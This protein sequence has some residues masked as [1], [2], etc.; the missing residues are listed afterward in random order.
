MNTKSK[1]LWLGPVI[2]A[3]LLVVFIA[4]CKKDDFK[5][6]P[7]VCPLVLSTNPT[8]GATSVPLNQIITATFNVKMNPLTINQASFTLQGG[9][10]TSVSGTISYDEA[11]A[12]LSFAPTTALTASTT[13]TGTIKSTV[14]DLSGSSLQTNYI[15]TFSTGNQITPSVIATDPAS[16]ATSVFLNKIVYATFSMEM[17]PLTIT[18]STFTLKQGT[19]NVAGTVAYLGTTASFN[20]SAA[21]ASNVLYTATITTAAK[22]LAGVPMV[23]NY[24]WTFTTGS[25]LAPIVI[26]TVPANNEA[27]VLLS[28][29]VTATFSVPMD[30]LTITSATFLLKN[31]TASVAGTVTFSGSTATFNPANDLLQNTVYTGTITVGAKNP[32]GT[33]LANNYQWTFT[34]ISTTPPLVISTDPIN[35]ATDV[36]LD[37]VVTATF[38]MPMDPLS[39]T[40]SSFTLKTGL[41]SVT[42]IVTYSG[43]T[44]YFDP[45]T[46]LLPNTLYT[47]IIT[48]GAKN[49]AG[50]SLA[51]NYSW[52][53]TTLS[54]T[55]PTI[56]LTD[57][58]NLATNVVLNKIV[59]AN[60]SMPMDPLSIN[61]LTFSLK[62]GSTAVTGLVSYLGTTASF[63]STTILLPGTVYTATITTGAKSIA[64]IAMASNYVWTFTTGS[65]VAP[66]VIST[67]PANN[68]SA[69]SL[70]KTIAASFSVAMNPL[71]INTTTFLLYNG[72]T[73]VTGVVSYSG[74]TASFN[75]AIDLLP[76][77]MY[78]ATIT[79][80]VENVAGIPLANNYVWTF[81]TLE[82]L[83][84]TV[85][86]T[87]P[88][89]N[90]TNV[91][92]NQTLE[93]IFSVPMDPLTINALTF[94]LFNGTTAVTG[95]VSYSGTT[96][97]FNPA[98]DLLPGTMYTATITNAAENVAGTPLANNYVWTF[99]TLTNPAPT[100]I[101]TVPANNAVN[102]ALDQSLEAT[103]SEAM[104]ATTLNAST[105]IM[106][107]G[108]NPVAGTISYS[109]TTASF[110]PS[111]DLLAGTEYTATI[112]TGA[113]NPDGTALE[114]DYVWTFTTLSLVAP[115][116]IS[117]IPANNESNVAINQI[118]S[119]TFS[120]PMDPMTITNLTFT[121]FEGA[122]PVI[123][124]ISYSGS[125]A[126]FTPSAALLSETVYTASITTGAMNVDGIPMENDYDWTFTTLAVVVPPAVDLLTV[127][128][129]G[130]IAGAGVSN[131]AGFSVINNLDVGISPGLRSS[132][133]GFPPAVIVNGEIYAADDAAPTPAML[134]QAKL[135]LTAAYL[136]AEGATEPAPATVSGDQGGLSLAPGIYKTTSTLLIQ[137]GDLT[138]DAG[139]DEN[140]FW[141]FQ[142][143]TGFTSIGG[144]GGSVILSG[145]AQAKNVFWQ[146]GSSATIGDYTTFQG[147]VLALT[148]ITMNSHATIS[149][150]VLCINGA[151]VMTDT[152]IITRP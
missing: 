120:E 88:A 44:V 136:Y 77:T 71:T 19:S 103:F 30:P 7:G 105:F 46:A 50:I 143:A 151:V 74:T 1:R 61:A 116:V 56:T 144:A 132:V 129:F 138:L 52:S 110:N 76:G 15:W 13:Y 79:N 70:D 147:N 43:S 39:L 113:M 80:A 92:L 102:V 11:T 14:K 137:N 45:A 34:T 75:P 26:S 32:A 125:T 60:F 115:T 62:N 37:K 134:I 29:N 123:G 58:L 38:N 48:T 107:E 142:I 130:I 69:V 59:T 67:D 122:N 5:E 128:R 106:F 18:S 124:V 78:T 12:T 111:A 97:S 109:G 66:T 2:T 133:T 90:A 82:S 53:F 104:N 89:N 24:V 117:T 99:T 114:N 145:G 94:T 96:A 81:T 119:A 6:I 91:V 149:G 57:P 95:I 112:T 23:N 140:A 73:P 72:L 55:A 9:L 42:G 146:V 98:I 27:G 108:S 131:N 22:S 85:I 3:I 64:G 28:A 51:A 150:R 25:I 8:N 4:G 68:A 101:S 41:T 83:A 152:N 63:A 10:K 36:A 20:P 21:L 31:G 17:D 54:T 141:I 135:D 139:G 86:S 35:N 87:V 148:S 16:N 47:G 126:S 121:L 49:L 33:P 100:V 40:N 127:E 84:P 65:V 93:A 118:I